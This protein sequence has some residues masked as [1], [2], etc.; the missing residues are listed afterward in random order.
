MKDLVKVKANLL[1]DFCQNHGNS[2]VYTVDRLSENGKSHYLHR[3]AFIQDLALEMAANLKLE[4][5]TTFFDDA[6][7]FASS[8][9]CQERLVEYF[10]SE[11]FAISQTVPGYSRAYTYP[12]MEEATTLAADFLNI[13][14]ERI[15]ANYASIQKQAYY[16]STHFKNSQL[17][18]DNPCKTI[19]PYDFKDKHNKPVSSDGISTTSIF[20]SNHVTSP[21]GINREL[22]S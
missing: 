5:S 18:D 19:V 15:T 12:I 3:N 14:N 11:S 16:Q 17:A 20:N 4:N 10:S 13:G 1:K 22:I 6:F 21:S 8:Q 7:K 2:W 9:R